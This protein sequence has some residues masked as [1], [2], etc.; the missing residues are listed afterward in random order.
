MEERSLKLKENYNVI[1]ANELIRGKH[2]DLTVL[3][4]KLIRL[5]ISQVLESDTEFKTYTCNIADLAR[6]LG[7]QPNHIYEAV[8]DLTTKV[9]Q[10]VICMRDKEP[11]KKGNYP[12]KKFHWLSTASYNNGTLKLKLSDELTPYLIGLNELFTRYNY[13]E[14]VNLPT[15]YS[16]RLFEL[17]VSFNNLPYSKTPT[18]NYSGLT[19]EKDEIALSID[20]LREYF[21]CED[22]YPLV[23]DFLRRVIEP[24]I[25]AIEEKTIM[26]VSCRKIKSGRSIVSLGF[27]ISD[28]YRLG[29]PEFTN[30]QKA[31]EEAKW[32]E[33]RRM[34]EQAAHGHSNEEGN[35]YYGGYY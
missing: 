26:R 34:Y 7:I 9:M 10:K 20:Y 23:A 21:N 22:K 6:F 5:A 12:W 1:Q 25:T 30:E 2:A 17:L 32:A 31:Q 13:S 15:Y 35:D 14:I 4:A 33:V 3:E 19:L 24:S 11:D 28:I 27:K 16:I 8:D 29:R 18:H